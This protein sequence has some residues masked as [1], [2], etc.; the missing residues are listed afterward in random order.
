M[1]R[2][3]SHLS[4]SARADVAR[5]LAQVLVDGLDLHSQIKIAHW[6]IK[7][8]HFAALHPLFDGFA[9]ALAAHNDALAERAAT[10]GAQVHGTARHVAAHSRLEEYPQGAT[11]DLDHVRLLASRFD[12]YL[13]GLR[14][15]RAGAE[16]DGDSDSADLLSTMVSDFEKHAWFLHASLAEAA[17]R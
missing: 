17:P 15:A 2:S 4:E 13:A 14:E 9:V 8:L 16:K 6:N 12:R 1:Y 5:H 7:G 10:L 3:P 11:R